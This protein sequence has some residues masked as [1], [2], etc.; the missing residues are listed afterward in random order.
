MNEVKN[1]ADVSAQLKKIMDHL[2]FLEK[3]IDTLL[4]KSQDRKPY[5][6][7]GYPTGNRS[8]G[9]GGNYRPGGNREGNRESYGQRP[10]GS[11]R[12]DQR[13]GGGHY[14]PRQGGHKYPS[15]RPRRPA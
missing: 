7:G 9:G 6:S 13:P 3:K 12:G 5:S 2:G 1:E 4:E 8:Y 11:G 14:G 15:H 10:Y